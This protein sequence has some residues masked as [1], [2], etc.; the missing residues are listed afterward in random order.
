M[1]YGLTSDCSFGSPALGHLTLASKQI[2]F[3]NLNGFITTSGH[4]RL[5][6]VG[7]IQEDKGETSEL[8]Q[9]C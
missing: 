6:L 7:G 8:W 1:A 3:L 9:K 4:L 2:L 5:D